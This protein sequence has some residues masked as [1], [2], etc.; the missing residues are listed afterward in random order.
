MKLTVDR[1]IEERDDAREGLAWVW[2]FLARWDTE[3]IDCLRIFCSK[4]SGLGKQGSVSGVCYY[5]NKKSRCYRISCGVQGEFPSDVL[6]SC[7]PQYRREDGTFP[8][9]PD[10]YESRGYRLDLRTGV[11]WRR[12]ARRIPLM[13]YSEALVYLVAHEVFHFLRRERQ[14]AGR[15]N[16]IDADAF[17]IARLQEFI[18]ERRRACAEKGADS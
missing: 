1:A 10:G 6:I 18:D 4:R 14:V 8:L 2:Q 9:V 3:K 17:A 11:A 5:P 12:L 16:N 7:K 15:N 13:D